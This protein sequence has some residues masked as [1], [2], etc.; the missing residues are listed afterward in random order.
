MGVIEMAHRIRL[1][2]ITTA[3]GLAAIIIQ[4]II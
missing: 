4:S 3:T 2:F 1:M